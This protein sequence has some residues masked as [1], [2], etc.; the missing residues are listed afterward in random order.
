MLPSHTPS[1]AEM[2]AMPM[3]H[4]SPDLSLMGG[5]RDLEPPRHALCAPSQIAFRPR[6][7]KS[8][9]FLTW[10]DAEIRMKSLYMAC[11]A[12]QEPRILFPW[13][14]LVMI[15]CVARTGSAR[16]ADRSD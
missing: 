3:L 13:H 7:R 10:K 5:F 9:A 4:R 6:R 14:F 12:F 11:R 16:G 15:I 2:L 8:T 1:A